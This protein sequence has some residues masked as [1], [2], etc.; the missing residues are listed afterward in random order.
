[1]SKF[2]YYEPTIQFRRFAKYKCDFEYKINIKKNSA[3]SK[4]ISKDTIKYKIVVLV[5]KKKN[6]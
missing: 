2:D 4:C 3:H 1:M 5:N 6:K